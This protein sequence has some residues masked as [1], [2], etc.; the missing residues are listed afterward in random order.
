MA[1]LRNILISAAAIMATFS[2]LQAARIPI[3]PRNTAGAVVRA[4]DEGEIPE[5]A[6][7]I[8]LAGVAPLLM[9]HKKQH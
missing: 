1:C 7:L 8:M 3:P 5:P 2:T 9:K 4:G 6:V